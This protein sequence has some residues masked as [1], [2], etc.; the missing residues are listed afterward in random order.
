MRP[1]DSPVF[2]AQAASL[3]ARIVIVSGLVALGLALVDF[4]VLIFTAD[5]AA[6]NGVS[7]FIEPVVDRGIVP[8]VG[9][10]LLFFGLWMDAQGPQSPS[11][12]SAIGALGAIFALV[13]GLSFAV[14]SPVYLWQVRAE[15]RS[16]LAATTREAREAEEQLE[17]DNFRS[18]LEDTF[19]QQAAEVLQDDNRFQELL[20]NPGLTPEQ[21]E[22]LEAA[23][24][25]PEQLEGLVEERAMEVPIAMLGEIRSRRQAR[26]GEIR[27]EAIR[28]ALRTGAS[29]FLLAASYLAIAWLSLREWRRSPKGAR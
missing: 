3:P 1:V 11:R 29:G 23:R 14:L 8:L 21:R 24:A 7:N 12:E 28:N 9:L 2:A 13:L 19:K 4:A 26:E 17:T 10:A 15:A 16:A 5:F 6:E 27:M 18:T 22:R 20:E 25:N